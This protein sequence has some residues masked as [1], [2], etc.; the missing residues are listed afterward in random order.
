[1]HT[2][3]KRINIHPSVA[4]HQITKCLV[5]L[6]APVKSLDATIICRNPECA[7]VTDKLRL[8]SGMI[9][10]PGKMDEC[11]AVDS[12][13]VGSHDRLSIRMR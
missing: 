12:Q 1:M 6:R 4:N 7:A 3:R 2:I 13:L 10:N 8:R 9:G 11:A 5:V